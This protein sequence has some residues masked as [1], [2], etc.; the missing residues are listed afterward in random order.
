MLGQYPRSLATGKDGLGCGDPAVVAH[1]LTRSVQ[2]FLRNG[3]GRDEG[4]LVRNHGA[5]AR[6]VPADG[7]LMR[8]VATT[9]RVEW[10]EFVDH[11]LDN[12]NLLGEE[13]TLVGRRQRHRHAL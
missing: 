4:G 1:E 11:A 9:G 6:H 3:F 13:N 2:V 5:L 12:L 7:L 10:A 8:V